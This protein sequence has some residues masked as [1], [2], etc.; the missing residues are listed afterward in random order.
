MKKIIGILVCMLF[1]SMTFSVA[2]GQIIQ[3]EDIKENSGFENSP[4]TN[5]IIT[6]PDIVRKNWVFLVSMVATDPEEDQIYYRIKVGEEGNPSNWVGPYDSGQE[7]ITGMGIFRY[8]GDLVIGIQ[9]KDE[10]GA[11]SDW[12]L[13]T[14]TFTNARSVNFTFVNLARIFSRLLQIF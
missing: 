10:H 7:Y 2:T 5:P 3:T 11:E 14:I 6:A 8:V 4:P 1:I 12:S 13:H 9:A